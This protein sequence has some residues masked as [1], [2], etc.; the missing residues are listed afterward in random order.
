MRILRV[1]DQQGLL[2]YWS[3]ESPP[4]PRLVQC[5]GLQRN[6]PNPRPVSVYRAE[7]EQEEMEAVAALFQVQ[8]RHPDKRFGVLFTDGDCR[9]AGVTVDESE[10]G[11]TGVQAVDGRH[12]NLRGTGQHFARLIVQI[13]KK[14]WEG[15]QLLRVYPPQQI[16]GQLAVLSRLGDAEIE[17]GT[18]QTC[19]EILAGVN[20]HTFHDNLARVEIRCRLQDDEDF[21]VSAWRGLPADSPTSA[22]PPSPPSSPDRAEP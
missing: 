10:R 8:P 18:R 3:A 4:L 12:V 20:W 9:E 6:Q 22:G 7:N 13:I 16:V 11:E 15:E 14:M 19:A 2:N 21:P 17:A 5:F 1:F